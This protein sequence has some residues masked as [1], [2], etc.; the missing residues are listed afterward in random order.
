MMNYKKQ[1]IV[2]VPEPKLEKDPRSATVSNGAFN[3]IVKPEQ[4]AV[5]G[6]KR[7]LAD[8]KKTAIVV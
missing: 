1:K 6:R 2:N 5:R 7:M 8:K 3:Y 4:V